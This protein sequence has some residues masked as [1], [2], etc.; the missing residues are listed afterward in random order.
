MKHTYLN[1]ENTLKRTIQ[2]YE[3]HGS[4]IVAVD[5]DNTLYDYHQQG[6]DC[7]EIIELL[8]DL[9]RIQ[10]KIIIWTA[11]EQVAFIKNHCHEH[12][13]PFDNINTNPPFFKSS[14]PK[15]YYN[16]LLDDRA[17]LAEVYHRLVK[18]V[19]YVDEK[20]VSVF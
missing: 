4:L 1:P 10:C 17:G 12:D 14:S 8:A 3:L 6:L 11:S 20:Q 16:E 19:R 5:F 9:R 18:L 15:I 13:I 7:G 2:E